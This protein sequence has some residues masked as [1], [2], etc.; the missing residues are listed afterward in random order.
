MK[1]V[2]RELVVRFR[3]RST[4]ASGGRS[5]PSTA[6]RYDERNGYVSDQVVVAAS[7]RK[8]AG[9]DLLDIANDLAAMDEVRFATP[10][11]V[12][13]FR[14]EAVTLPSLPRSGTSRTRGRVTGQK[15]GEDV[16]ALGA[17]KVSRGRPRVVVAVLDDGVDIEHPNLRGRIWGNPDKTDPRTLRARLLPPGR[18][19][20]SL[21][22]AAKAV[23]LPVRSDSR[24]TTSTA[25]RVPVWWRR[26]GADAWGIA[27]RCRIL[28][29]KVFHADDLAADERVADAIRYSATRAAVLSCSWSGRQPGH[30]VSIGGHRRPRSEAD[31]ARRS[32]R[33]RERT[34]AAGR[35]PGE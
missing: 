12:S 8:V 1:T 9:A 29:V 34:W 35:L 4:I 32:S 16:T 31:W 25:H 6:W 27:H 13:E 30:R 19:S 28:A 22:P 17:W 3:Q 18:S 11:F 33:H 20:R 7:N 23:P 14:R 21:Q 2:Y 10:N 5:W 26:P 15:K 24:A